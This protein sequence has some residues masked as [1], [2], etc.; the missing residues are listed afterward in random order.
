MVLVSLQI[1]PDGVQRG[2]IAVV[3]KRFE[4]KGYKLVAIKVSFA[5]E[6]HATATFL[7]IKLLIDSFLL[8]RQFELC[9]GNDLVYHFPFISLLYFV[10]SR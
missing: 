8:A 9:L 10:T 4:D 3:I 7:A 5:R 6:G 1:K 2:L